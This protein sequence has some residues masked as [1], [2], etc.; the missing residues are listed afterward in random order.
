MPAQESAIREAPNY[1]VT[2]HFMYSDFICPCCDTLRIVP[3]FYSHVTL[4]ERM[5]Q[6]LGFPILVTSGFRCRNYN[7][8]IGGAPKSWHLLFA[9][10]VKPHDGDR[11]KLK[12]M[13]EIAIKLGFGGTGSYETHIHVDLR[14]EPMKWRG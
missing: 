8:Q 5:R 3:G 1:Y 10:D 2:E 12:I 4:L 11:D 13:Y 9:T 7:A 6:E 14:P